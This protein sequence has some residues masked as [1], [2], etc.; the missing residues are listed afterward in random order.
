MGGYGIGAGARDVFEEGIWIPITKLMRA[1]ERND[2]VW[3]F[4]LS[5]VRQP[6][7]MAGDLHA[8]MA[9]AEVG[10]QRLAALCD[11]YDLDDIEALAEEI[12]SRSEA[13]TRASIRELAAGTYEATAVLDLADGST[14]DIVCAVTVD[15]GAG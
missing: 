2:D 12:I 10:A 3:N 6:D 7:H 8:Q 4:I 5:N 11:T 14:I 13:A 1:G 9:S 15:P